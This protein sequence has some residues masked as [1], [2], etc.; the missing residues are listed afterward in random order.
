MSLYFIMAFFYL[1]PMTLEDFRPIQNSL[2][3]QPG[4]Y[5]FVGAENKILYVGKAKNLWNRVTSY[6]VSITEKNSRLQLLVKT[7]KTI[8]FTIVDSENEALLL[9]N[10]LIKEHQP[11]Y[12]ILL[13]D[14][15]TYPYICIH[16]ER[17]ARVSIQRKIVKDGSEYFGPYPSNSAIYNM[18]DIIHQLFPL[19]TCT[20]NLS[21]KNIKE[22]KL[23]ACLEYQIGNCKAPCIG[24]E[25]ELNYKEYITQIKHILKG[26][27]A[28]AIDYLNSQMTE[29]ANELAF[30]K[31]ALTKKKLESL[32]AFK[33]KSTVVNPNISN[34]DVFT[35]VQ[36][37][38]YAF[39]N[40]LKVVNGTV[41]LTQSIELKKQLDETKEDL[42]I[43][44]IYH[45]RAVFASTNTDLIVPFEIEV[46]EKDWIFTIPFKG[47]KKHLLDLSLKNAIYFKNK[48]LAGNADIKMKTEEFSVLK[49]LQRDFRLT[50]LPLHI[51]CFDNSNIQGAYPVSAMVVF[52]KGKPSKSDYRHY[53]IKTVEGPNDFASMEEVI[54]RRYS[55]LIA[56]Q[57]PLPQLIII[58][59]GKGQLSSAYEIIKKLD[60]KGKVAIASI[61]KRLEEIYMPNDSLPL[62]ISKKS[63][64]LKLIQ[65]LRDEAH[66]FGITHHRSQR[67]KATLMPE[68]TKIK[69][70]GAASNLVL[71]KHFKS[72]AQVK[73]ATLDQ[74]NA[75]VS[76]TIAQLVYL[77]FN[78]NNAIALNGEKE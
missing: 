56:E 6:F 21:E 23:K 48:R 16:K 44:A 63:P 31:A 4:I 38:D 46:H 36:E 34:V 54:E 57:A 15:K 59:G 7:A 2:P 42:L 61:A 19:R 47:D 13:K 40:Y 67:N 62:Y 14:G 55:R 39:V 51:E 73:L 12:N 17:F 10:S 41:I 26:N 71:L 60:L 70:V 30:E 22:Q 33:E 74:L 68:L 28:L 18:F 76:T 50:E 20:L 65:Q 53:N 25:T 32:K 37:E 29:Y 69:G 64:S 72:V 77:H 66:R 43:Y 1:R 58:D 45:L 35:L 27:T 8:D 75:I 78:P 11:K 24:A 3:K 49:E 9:E 5:K 52:K